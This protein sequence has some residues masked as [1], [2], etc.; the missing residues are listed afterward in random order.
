M[1]P[2]SIGTIASDDDAADDDDDVDDHQG[3]D[4][5]ST[6]GDKA[7]PVSF[8]SEL[9]DEPALPQATWDFKS[10][11]KQIKATEHRSQ[12]LT[13]SL[14]DKIRRTV[15]DRSAAAAA[16]TATAAAGAVDDHEGDTDED[17]DE[18]EDITRPLDVMPSKRD[19]AQAQ[20]LPAT[21]RVDTNFSELH[22]SRPLLKALRVLGFAAPTPIQVQAIPVALRGLD[23]LGSAV[24]G[25]GKTAAYLLPILERL[26]FRDRRAA[27]ATRVLI[28]VPARELAQQVASMLEKL[29][30][31]TDVSHAVVVGGLS[32]Q[33]QAAELR[34][35]P[36]VLLVTPGRL[37]DHLRN[38]VSFDL[39]DLEVLVLDEADRLLEL[40]FMAELKELVQFVP[41][42]RQTL[43]FSATMT[44]EVRQLAELSLDNP[45]R[46]QADGLF[47]VSQRLVQE[48]CRV[49]PSTEGETEEQR[50][51][52]MLLAL[53]TR[54]CVERTIVFFQRKRQAHRLS[55]LFGL[56][57]LRATELHGNL[58][59]VQRLE[60]LQHFREGKVDFLLCTDLAARGLDIAG[61]KWVVNF[62]MPK[63]VTTYVHRVGRTARAGKGGASI[64]F[65]TEERRA[66][67]R[68]LLKSAAGA[69]AS[70]QTRKIGPNA[71]VKAAARLSAL[72]REV[73]AVLEQE[74]VERQM[75][76]ADMEV[77]KASNMLEHRDEIASRP[78]R[79]WFQSEHE[80]QTA[81]E[82]EAAKG[83]DDGRVHRLSRD[84]RRRIEAL[85]REASEVKR[86]RK[87]G[88]GG[89]GADVKPVVTQRTQA[90]AFKRSQRARSNGNGGDDDDDDVDVDAEDARRRSRRLASANGND[91]EALMARRLAK[92][93]KHTAKEEAAEWK[94]KTRPTKK[95]SSRPTTGRFHSKARFKRK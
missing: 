29:G 43:L 71:I 10:A 40:G 7:A 30:Q 61:V 45:V 49:R 22:L 4:V 3:G 76:L 90:K 33:A 36:D 81:R 85:Q 89:D 53:V 63:D 67:M 55:I 19:A 6:D 86:A 69:Q 34:A 27:P 83:A 44:T 50:A 88:G 95:R 37:I 5:Q 64:T 84:K 51:E 77:T 15:E 26:L 24:T 31:F 13:T 54:T 87:E 2:L 41:K 28:V 1:D 38:T 20:Q 9:M 75:R 66:V 52:A 48:F 11:I 65:V 56:C 72:E 21:A 80:K 39:D 18:Q 91:E 32:L 47:D 8:F 79:T 73:A 93:V 35:R 62:E 14:D 59:Q 78:R 57:G 23:V 16:L 46:V 58:T 70:L 60:A 68:D 74:R 82:Q 25:S 94:E 12:R 42:T 17:D 92:R